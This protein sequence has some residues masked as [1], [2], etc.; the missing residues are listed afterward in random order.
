MRMVDVLMCAP[1]SWAECDQ[2]PSTRQQWQPATVR[3]VRLTTKEPIAPEV[4]IVPTSPWTYYL[5][6]PVPR[7]PS[8]AC[9]D[10]YRQTVVTRAVR[11]VQLCSQARLSG[12]S[13]TRG[14]V[15]RGASPSRNSSARIPSMAAAR[16]GS[17]GGLVAALCQR[18]AA[19]PTLRLFHGSPP[20]H[21]CNAAIRCNVPAQRGHPSQTS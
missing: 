14:S 10:S 4:E 1:P 20:D 18:I 13:S 3:N 12:F 2:W 11:V 6:L 17:L 8:P 15:N 21:P 19:S 16:A 7:L 9:P 5:G